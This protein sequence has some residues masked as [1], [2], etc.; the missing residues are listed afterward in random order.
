MFYVSFMITFCITWEAYIKIWS[1]AFFFCCTFI[2]YIKLSYTSLA[3]CLSPPTPPIVIYQS[4]LFITH[5]LHPLLYTSL[6]CLSPTRSTHCYIPVWPVYPPPTPPIAIH[7]SHPYLS[8]PTPPIVIYQSQPYLSPTH[9]THCYIPVWSVYHPSTPPI[10]IYLSDLFI[11]HPLHPLL[12]TS[13]TPIYAQ[14]LHPLLYTSHTPIYPPP[15]PPIV[16]YQSC[17]YL[18]PTHSTHC[19]IPVSPLFIHYPLHH[20]RCT[21]H[22]SLG[23]SSVHIFT[24]TVVLLFLHSSS[25]VINGIQLSSVNIYVHIFTLQISLENDKV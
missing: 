1:Y 6:V 4:D 2:T 21:S 15:T 19:Y 20:L 5:P 13:H 11:P 18:S 14:P 7:Q 3:P 9:S 17:P 22:V 10:V 8:P 23:T 16:I 25:S 24:F 12:Y